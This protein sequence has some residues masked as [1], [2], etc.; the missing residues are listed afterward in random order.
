MTTEQECQPALA[1]WAPSA[2]QT[3]AGDSAR[4]CADDGAEFPP[5]N[6]DWEM[7]DV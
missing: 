1:T 6:G 5:D 2:Q 4:C 3:E 7:A